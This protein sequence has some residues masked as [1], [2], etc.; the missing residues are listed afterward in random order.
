MAYP[1]KDWICFGTLTTEQSTSGKT[2]IGNFKELMDS[3]GRCN[4]SFG[5]RLHWFARVEGKNGIGAEDRD[6]SKRTHLHFMLAKHKVTDGH[7]HQFTIPDA[8]QYL[9]RAW[10]PRFGIADV[11]PYDPELPGLD[12]ALKAPG[13]PKSEGWEDTVEISPALFSFLKKRKWLTNYD[14]RD[15]DAVELM[16]AMRRQGSPVCF[17]DEPAAKLIKKA[18]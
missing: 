11:R 4:Q 9:K 17:L 14:D 5:K 3:V 18:S 10:D 8:C 6:P 1:E 12:Y 13:G 15:P 7:K 16:L 2:L